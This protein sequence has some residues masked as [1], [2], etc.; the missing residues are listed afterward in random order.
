[1]STTFTVRIPRELKEKMEQNPIEWSQEVR[2][3]LEER[4]KQIELLK[5]LQ[6]IEKRAEKRKT[7]T[8]STLLIREDRERRA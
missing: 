1:M 2:A 7:K 6:E 4:V 5:T 8:D 3:F